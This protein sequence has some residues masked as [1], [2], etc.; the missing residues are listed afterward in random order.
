MTLTVACSIILL[1][2]PWTPGDTR[3]AEDLIRRIG[4]TKNVKSYWM[5]GF[6]LDKQIDDMIESKE[7]A[8]KAVLGEGEVS[9]GPAAKINIPRLLNVLIAKVN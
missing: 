9:K 3:Q 1:D 4:Q 6:E 5:T 7:E 8:S 2:R